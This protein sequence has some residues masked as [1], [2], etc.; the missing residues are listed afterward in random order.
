MMHSIKYSGADLYPSKIVC[1]GRNYADHAKELGNKIP[2]E[3]VIFIKPNSAIS[4]TLVSHHRKN[5][6]HYELELCF[7]IENNQFSGLGVGLDLTKRELQK[8]LK[9]NG[10]PWERAKSFDGSAVFSEFIALDKKFNIDNLGIRLFIDV[11]MKQSGKVSEML[12]KPQKLVQSI[13]TFISFEDGDILMTGTP[14]G[15]GPINSGA[16]FRAEVLDNEQIILT[17]QWI[18]S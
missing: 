14:E 7:L 6:L 9:S 18:A 8:I 3:P 2:E 15:V 1:V 13:Q 11:M 16:T 17:C 10:L 4:N 5:A 12:F